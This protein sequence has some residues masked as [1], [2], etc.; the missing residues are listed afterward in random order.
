MATFNIPLGT[1]QTVSSL[2]GTNTING[3]STAAYGAGGGTLDVTGDANNATITVNGGILHLG[4]DANH[5]TITLNNSSLDM[6]GGRDLNNGTVN[7]G[8]GASS[9]IASP[10]MATSSTFGNVHF[11]GVASGD[12][13]STGGTGAITGLSYNGSTHVLSFTQGGVTY[14]LSVTTTG[15]PNFNVGTVNGHP[16]IVDGVVVCFAAGTLIRTPRGAA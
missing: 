16:V 7:Y 6:S 1:T 14:G 2:S 5:A 9:F 15:T 8:T 3:N 12:V 11:T 13:I 4:H 10:Q